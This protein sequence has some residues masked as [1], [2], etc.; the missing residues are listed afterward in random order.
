MAF[1]GRKSGGWLARLAVAAMATVA[2]P[3]LVG[4][5]GGSAIAGAFSNVPI[6]QLEVPS[7]AMG[8]NIRV[9][10]TS[11]GP[12]SRALYLLDSMEAGEDFN[13]WESTGTAVPGCRS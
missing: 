5:A 8:R 10:F 4:V 6:E 13:G 12:N 1:G 9:E 3:G 2:L 11:G 7:Q